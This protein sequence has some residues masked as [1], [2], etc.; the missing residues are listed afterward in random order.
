[1]NAVIH[2]DYSIKGESIRL[3]MFEDRLEIQ[4]PGKLLNGVT[5]ENLASRQATRNE[6]LVKIL[7]RMPVAGMKGTQN[8]AY[9]LEGRGNGIPIIQKKTEELSGKQPRFKTIDNAVFQV[10]I[11]AAILEHIPIQTAVTAYH[12]GRPAA[13]ICVLALFPNKTGKEAVSDAEGRALLNLHSSHLPMT[14]FAAGS[15]YAAEIERNWIPAE[16]ALAL[17]LRKLHGGGSLIF[18]DAT[19]C[20]PN[21]SGRLNPI[22]DADDRTYLYA[23]NISINEGRQQPVRFSFGE[24]LRLTDAEGQS[25][26]VRIVEI[27]GQSAVV[28]Y[29]R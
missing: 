27:I 14:V 1:M 12:E 23:A 16:R 7:S 28:E 20:I 2:R 6:V 10:T 24:D 21:V 25:A 15:G 19:G 4:S 29:E 26:V 3:S 18:S 9:I 8:R 17:N 5:D 13:D 22:R 11:P